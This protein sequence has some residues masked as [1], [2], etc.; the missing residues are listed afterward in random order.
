MTI[1]SF[2]F[3]NTAAEEK[4]ERTL[5]S[6]MA[7]LST[8]VVPYILLMVYSAGIPHNPIIYTS[9]R[10][11]CPPSYV[12]EGNRI[13]MVFDNHCDNIFTF[14]L[15]H[16]EFQGKNLLKNPSSLSYAETQRC[17]EGATSY[18]LFLPSYFCVNSTCS[19]DEIPICFED[20][21]CE[22]SN[23]RGSCGHLNDNQE[24]G[25]KYCCKSGTITLTANGPICTGQ[26]PGS[27]CTTDAVCE[28]H[29]ENG[30]CVHGNNA[31]LPIGSNC[32]SHEN[33]TTYY[34]NWEQEC[35]ILPV[36]CPTYLDDVQPQTGENQ[37]EQ[38]FLAELEVVLGYTK[39]PPVCVTEKRFCEDNHYPIVEE[40]Y[41]YET[42]I[43]MLD[44]VQLLVV[45]EKN[46]TTS[47]VE[48]DDNL[49]PL[50]ILL[51]DDIIPQIS[52]HLVGILSFLSLCCIVYLHFY[53]SKKRERHYLTKK[54]AQVKISTLINNAFEMHQNEDEVESEGSTMVSDKCQWILHLSVH[55]LRYS[56]LIT[57]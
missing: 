54:A 27:P 15:N 4:K 28:G 47:F 7:I 50:E 40:S 30:I 6:T 20:S 25:D 24:S 9:Y 53:G 1:L 2:G 11:I 21:D 48:Q 36:I 52:L 8:S 39:V 43:P 35:D 19:L 44:Y 5:F 49:S 18:G 31:R 23:Y 51:H 10:N 33:C 42:A 45:K 12:A 26:A 22:I 37:D 55:S 34:C 38:D 16:I 41:C 56:P 46:E 17:I 32:T 29:C 57:F 14:C 13:P 3:T